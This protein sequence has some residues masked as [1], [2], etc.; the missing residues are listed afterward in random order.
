[1]FGWI[2]SELGFILGLTLISGACFAHDL[3]VSEMHFLV[4]HHA[5][6]EKNYGVCAD[7]SYQALLT[8]GE[9][10][11][12]FRNR[13]RL[14]LAFCQSWLA[15]KGLAAYHIKQVDPDDLTASERKLWLKLK[16]H[17]RAEIE[18]QEKI[19]FVLYPYYGQLGFSAGS[20]KVT[21][22]YFGF[23]SDILAPGWKLTLGAESLAVTMVPQ[24][25]NYSQGMGLL[26]LSLPLG[27]SHIFGQNYEREWHLRSAYIYSDLSSQIGMIFQS[28]ISWQVLR[29]TRLHFDGFY[30][31]YPNSSLG[32]LR[33]GQSSL[34]ID[35]GLYSR[36]NFE[37][38][39]SVGFH[40]EFPSAPNSYDPMTGFSLN[41]IYNRGSVSLNARVGSFGLG[42]SYWQGAEAFGVRED[43]AIIFSALELHRS[44]WGFNAVWNFY[45]R[46]SATFK[47]TIE[48]Y[49]VGAIDVISNSSYGMVTFWL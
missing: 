6:L 14:Y 10:D 31:L 46:I 2:R 12:V 49:S 22:N 21:G 18:T 7:Q 38:G 35:Q 47:Y 44:G 17:L 24:L 29:L 16:A 34:S 26:G 11:G 40:S 33:V 4:G 48:R 5:Y 13:A 15:M 30:S 43:A 8:T 41:R 20:P 27:S 36:P 28:G 19:H 1:M 32:S 3:S 45:S 9:I 25:S 23:Y 39:F 42:G 37:L